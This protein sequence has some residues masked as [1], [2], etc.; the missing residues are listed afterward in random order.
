MQQNRKSLER[1]L[2]K[3]SAVKLSVDKEFAYLFEESAGKMRS[4]PIELPEVPAMVGLTEDE[5]RIAEWLESDQQRT[6]ARLSFGSHLRLMEMLASKVEHLTI[7]V[8]NFHV[9]YS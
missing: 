1:S 7:V 3:E 2:Y 9:Y 6:L 4:Q 5:E 8:T